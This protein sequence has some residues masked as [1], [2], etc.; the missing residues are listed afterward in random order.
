MLRNMK[1]SA[2]LFLSFGLVMLLVLALGLFGYLGMNDSANRNL[3]MGLL[4]GGEA[5]ALVLSILLAMAVARNL[6]KP[7]DKLVTVAN[8]LASG[9]MS[10][11]V[12]VGGKDEVGQLANALKRMAEAVNRMLADTNMM[13]ESL[14]AGK[15]AIRADASLHEGEYGKILESFNAALEAI[16]A[17]VD[18][19]IAVLMNISNNDLTEKLEGTY[20]GDMKVLARAVNTTI[21]H[22]VNIQN[23]FIDLSRGDWS[24]LE[25][26][27]QIGARSE[28]DQMLPAIVKTMNTLNGLIGDAN[29]LSQQAVEGNLDIRVDAEKYEGKYSQLIGGINNIIDA[30]AAPLNEARGVLESMANNDFSTG[31]SDGYKGSFDSLSQSINSVLETLNQTMSEINNAAEQVAA[32]TRQLAAGSQALSQGA[33]EQAGAIEQ[34]T[35]SLNDV[36]GQTRQNAF[37]A[38][39]ASGLA[40]SARDNAVDGNGRM[41]ELQKAMGEINDASASISKI[42]KV[43]DEIAFQTNLLALNA[44]VEAARAGQHGKGFAVVAEEVRN[45]AQRSAGAAKETTAM[46]EESIKKTKQGTKIANETA[47]ALVKIVEGVE[48]ATDLVGGI[49]AASNEQASAVAQVNKGVEQVS[50][51][52]QTNSATAEESAAASEELSSQA[53]LL[54]EMV[55]R[56]SLRGQSAPGGQRA[57]FQPAEQARALGAGKAARRPGIALNDRE[58]G[59]Y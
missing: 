42:I 39:E 24:R 12:D 31:M 48:K 41:K 7:M 29:M 15:L 27:E 57:V 11:R 56:F 34:L 35:A 13:A 58:F 38:N 21:E 47:S 16:I 23:V 18:Q 43:I 19:S 17:P 10:V 1:I 55:G 6:K 26:F 46:I 52:T 3:W 8:R 44:A 45:L 40:V 54:K 36:A 49:A 30:M 4:F 20:S 37:H 2:K 59:K 5:A 51:V 28:N 25:E 9:D 33:T 50:Q 14:M 53:A 32:G 22:M